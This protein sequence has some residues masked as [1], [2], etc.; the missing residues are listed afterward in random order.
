[1]MITNSVPGSRQDLQIE[2]A[3][4]LEECRVHTEIEKPIELAQGGVNVDV[5]AE[6]II[7]GCR[8]LIFCECKYWRSKI[9]PACNP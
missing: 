8:N 6:E 9:P 7:H 3:K 5:Y 2:T 1:M 4:I